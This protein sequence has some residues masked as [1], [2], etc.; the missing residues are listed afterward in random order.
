LGSLVWVLLGHKLLG[1]EPKHL[2]THIQASHNYVEYLREYGRLV[3]PSGKVI[4]ATQPT[5][6]DRDV[7]PNAATVRMALETAGAS[8]IREFNITPRYPKM[9]ELRN[10][11][12]TGKRTTLRHTRQY[13]KALVARF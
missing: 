2:S 10:G 12:P 1:T 7:Y 3:G 13:S 11:K 4:I 6:P 9:P 5:G 8:E